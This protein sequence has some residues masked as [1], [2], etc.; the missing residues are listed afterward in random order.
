MLDGLRSFCTER[1]GFEGRERSAS[2][3]EHAGLAR[4]VLEAADTNEP[5]TESSQA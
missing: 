4:K 5:I 1:G 2:E 3:V